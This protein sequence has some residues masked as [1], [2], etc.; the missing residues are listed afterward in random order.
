MI[1]GKC[2]DNSIFLFFFLIMNPVSIFSKEDHT[3]ASVHYL[4]Y[5]Q[6]PPPCEFF[7]FPKWKIPLKDNIW[8]RED[9]EQ[10]TT[11]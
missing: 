8:E 2:L 10:N 6:Q 1:K 3:I 7:L 5:E 9:I 11:V 4:P